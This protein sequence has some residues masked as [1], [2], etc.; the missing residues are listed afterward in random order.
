MMSTGYRRVCRQYGFDM[1]YNK[2]S[3]TWL[4]VGAGV[5]SSWLDDDAR[6]QQSTAWHACNPSQETT[7]TERRCCAATYSNVLSIARK[8]FS[9]SVVARISTYILRK[10]RNYILVTWSWPDSCTNLHAKLELLYKIYKQILSVVPSNSDSV[11]T[12]QWCTTPTPV[13]RWLFPNSSPERACCRNSSGSRCEC[14]PANCH[15][16]RLLFWRRNRSIAEWFFVDR[17]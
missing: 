3:V 6:R 7:H 1:D 11:A 8:R 2:Y 13:H 4:W 15:T 16:T 17:C 9:R 10:Q 14:A 5:S 12:V